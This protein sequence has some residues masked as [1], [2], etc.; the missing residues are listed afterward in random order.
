M[1]AAEI[2]LLEDDPASFLGPK[3]PAYSKWG[4]QML[5]ASGSCSFLAKKLLGGGFSN[6]FYFHPYLG[7]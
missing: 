6:I 4:D 7:R 5:F 2:C 3:R 1:I